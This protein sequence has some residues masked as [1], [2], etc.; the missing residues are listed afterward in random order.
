MVMQ[1]SPTELCEGASLNASVG[2]PLD[3]GPEVMV[4]R[5]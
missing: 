1:N 4:S 5:G 3:G 2:L